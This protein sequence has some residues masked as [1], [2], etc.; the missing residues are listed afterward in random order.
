MPD[1]HGLARD[2]IIAHAP[3]PVVV[4]AASCGRIVHPAAR[5]SEGPRPLH[6]RLAHALV[7]VL[8]HAR[9]TSGFVV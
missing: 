6:W 5:P 2:A 4:A 8:E 1:S 3:E 9:V 7:K